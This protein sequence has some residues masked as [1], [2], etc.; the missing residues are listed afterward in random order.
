MILF[1]NLMHTVKG[2]FLEQLGKSV[3][4]EQQKKH[5]NA[6]VSWSRKHAGRGKECGMALK[7]R[8]REFLGISGV[9]LFVVNCAWD[10]KCAS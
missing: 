1:K 6:Q 3:Q 2:Y 9:L 5:K 8:E 10:S 7:M 4:N